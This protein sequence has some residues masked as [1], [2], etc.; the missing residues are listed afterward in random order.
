[1]STNSTPG[2]K[3]YGFEFLSIFIAVIAAFALN[4]WSAE[5]KDRHAEEKILL[6]IRRGLDKDL[7]DMRTNIAGH[8]HG[9]AGVRYWQRVL[10]K[11]P[12]P[13]D[14]AA[15]HLMTVARDFINLQN[16][17]GYGSLKSRGLE[18]VVDDSL[19]SDIIT[20]YEYDMV[21]L[22]KLEEEYA[23]ME[24]HHSYYPALNDAVAPWLVFNEAGSPTGL[25]QPVV[26]PPA[27]R[28]RLLALLWKIANNRR[29]TLHYYG[30]VEERVK[31]V[32]AHI[33]T[34]L[35]R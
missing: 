10:L 24:Y 27:E 20:L 31:A 19:R 21:I 1:M 3:R 7:E 35:G 33:S 16:N 34:V 5:R 32:Q 29:F 9:L 15:V 6:E 2:W 11:Q 8:E 4:S 12:V 30:V 26:V 14:S 17:S 25:K 28:D 22:Q 13:G 18:L 23:E